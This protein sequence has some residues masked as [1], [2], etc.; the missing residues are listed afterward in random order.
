MLLTLLNP[1]QQIPL[2]QWSFESESI[3]HIG[4]SPE[5]HVVIPNPLVSRQHLELQKVKSGTSSQWYLVNS[6]TDGTF[7]NGMPIEQGW[8]SDGRLIQLARAHSAFPS[9][10]D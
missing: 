8:I 4:R 6:G 9:Y 7:V 3:V 2:Q 5:N 1:E 10:Y